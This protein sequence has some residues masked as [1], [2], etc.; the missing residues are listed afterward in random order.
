[1]TI[2]I[3]KSTGTQV[4]ENVM[5]TYLHTPSKQY[6]AIKSLADRQSRLTGKKVTIEACIL[7][8]LS[9][10]KDVVAEVRRLRNL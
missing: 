10:D 4:K 6:Y 8:I 3:K 2:A 9:R 1:M 7:S 5:T